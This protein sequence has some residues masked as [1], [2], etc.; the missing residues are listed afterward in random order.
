MNVIK[1]L[2]MFKIDISKKVLK[3]IL[4]QA[5]LFGL[6]LLQLPLL[7]KS[8]YLVYRNLTLTVTAHNEEV[9][10]LLK[11]FNVETSNWVAFN[12]FIDKGFDLLLTLV[13]QSDRSIAAA[14]SNKIF[15]GCN[16]V[17]NTLRNINI[18]VKS[19][20]NLTEKLLVH[21]SSLLNREVLVFYCH[22]LGTLLNH[23]LCDLLE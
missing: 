9:R 12:R 22:E 4:K 15:D 20:S 17:Y 16:A 23:L 18:A 5:L 21:Q 6:T 14:N 13:E 2:L 19:I 10:I 3:C 8:F 1:C 11:S 7:V